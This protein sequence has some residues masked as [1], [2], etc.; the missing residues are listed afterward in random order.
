MGRSGVMLFVAISTITISQVWGACTDY[1][2]TY[3]PPEGKSKTT[4]TVDV[5]D[6]CN[7]ETNVDG[8]SYPRPKGKQSRYLILKGVFLKKDQTKGKG[9]LH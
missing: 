7:Y 1:V 8:E 5:G 3:N 2:C 4:M 6:K 9:R